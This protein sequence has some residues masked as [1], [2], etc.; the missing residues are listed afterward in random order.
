MKICIILSPG[1]FPYP[2]T[3]GGAQA[4]FNMIDC[5][6]HDIKIAMIFAYKK[7]EEKYVKQLK[8]MWSNIEFFGFKDSPP[9][10]KKFLTKILNAMASKILKKSVFDADKVNPAYIDFFCR[11][12]EE[13]NFD[14][15]HAET[16]PTM[17]YVYA[18]NPQIKRIFVHQ[19]IRYIRNERLAK[20]KKTLSHYDNFLIQKNRQEEIAAMNMYDAIVTLTDIDKNILQK[21]GVK[22]PI[23]SSPA[24]TSYRDN[25]KEDYEFKNKI[26]FL[27]NGG[28]LPN[29]EGL[30][31]FA[32][33]IWILVKKEC[34]DV[35]FNVIGNWNRKLYGRYSDVNF[36]G[37]VENLEQVL[38][39]AIMVVPLLTG[40]G[41]RIKILDAVNFGSP[42]VT[43]SIGIE[44]LN[45]EN[46][47]DCVIE[48]D[49]KN[50]AEKLCNLIRDEAKQKELRK[51][52]KITMD[53][54]YS[55]EVLL[56]KRL[57]VYRSVR[58]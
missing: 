48:D 30:V 49:A 45:F 51:N 2:L 31:W 50:F 29:S 1:L 15:I 53:R 14:V 20:N 16:F 25:Y 6:R 27:A 32:E 17:N 4:I 35:Q 57:D 39:G 43:T 40:S 36:L 37:F 33:N 11:V 26:A 13:N 38:D 28:H 41:M 55:K 42:V 5:L 56:K 44:G 3:N 58:R 12:L 7:K 54:F 24:I 9:I 52:A 22:V 8:N 21:D 46:D 47:R 23:Y 34:P 10:H 18:V 19:E